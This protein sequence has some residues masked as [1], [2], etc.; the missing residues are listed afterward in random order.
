MRPIG[1][2]PNQ[3]GASAFG[4]YLIAN[5]IK[6]QI[7]AEKDGTFAVW[8]Y[9]EDD[10]SRAKEFLAQYL[11]RPNDPKFRNV[12]EQAR[13]VLDA[14]KKDS[15]DYQKRTHDRRQLWPGLTSGGIGPVTLVLVAVSIGVAFYAKIPL[16]STRAPDVE[17]IR[18]LW[19]TYS[20]AQNSLPEVQ[21]GQVWRLITPI[22]IHMSV[23]HIV[24]NLLWLRDL[25]T[26]IEQR[27]SSWHL[28]ALVLIMGVLSNVGQ[29]F[30]G[31]AVPPGMFGGMSGVVYGLLGYIW[32]RGKFD[33]RSGLYLHQETVIMMLL[34]LVLCFTGAVGR[35]ANTAHVVGL[36][37]GMA[38]GFLSSLPF[39]G[40][41]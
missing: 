3:S 8:I 34:W 25:G 36:I 27:Q 10:L 33:P 23:L 20:D 17:A 21:A 22:F 30:I 5:G 4:D 41:S 26:M 7:E 15:E 18:G 12:S 39:K 1:H 40:K 11:A 35:I 2:L 32:I 9:S 38:W 24:F 16:L 31:K 6:S 14:E 37:A 19:I 29:F 28:A 13:K